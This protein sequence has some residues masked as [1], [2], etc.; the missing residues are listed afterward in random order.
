MNY[1]SLFYETKCTPQNA[2]S[3][4]NNSFRIKGNNC[5]F[6][7]YYQ[8]GLASTLN[9]AIIGTNAPKPKEKATFPC[10]IISADTLR[11]YSGLITIFDTGEIGIYIGSNNNI[12]YIEFQGC[13]LCNGSYPIA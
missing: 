3:V 10:T 11:Y 6:N 12:P 1:S 7:Y 5:D 2:W 13:I 4:I 9:G 8:C